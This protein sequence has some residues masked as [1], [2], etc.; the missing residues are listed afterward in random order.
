[1]LGQLRM[2]TV[3]SRIREL[4]SGFVVI[5]YCQERKCVEKKSGL[6]L[7]TTR[8]NKNITLGVSSVR[9]RVGFQ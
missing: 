1:M 9:L 5:Y 2:V 7:F 8:N 4:G 6:Q 3:H